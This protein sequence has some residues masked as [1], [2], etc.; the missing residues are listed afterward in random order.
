MN[1]ATVLPG[2]NRTA[3]WFAD[4][5]PGT[6]FDSIEKVLLHTTE[7]SGWPGYQGGAVAPNLTGYPDQAARAMLWRAHFPVN[8]SSRALMHT[9]TQPTNGDHVVQIELVGTC[10]PG[11][12]GLY[13]PGAPEWALAGVADMLA[14]LHAEW[15]VPLVST[16]AWRAYNAPGDGQRLSDN[17]YD[18]YRGILGHQHAPQ[19]DHR[20]PGALNVARVLQ[21]AT[22]TG[23]TVS[24]ENPTL[25]EIQG[26]ILYYKL[27]ANHVNPLTMLTRTYD[28]VNILLAKEQG[29]DAVLSAITAALPGLA[30]DVAARVV[31]ALPATGSGTGGAITPADVK[32]AVREVLTEGTGGTP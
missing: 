6:V 5:H 2:A 11:G 19:N 27:D 1:R 24:Q 10:V 23:G 20:D 3:Q 17:A 18:A 4:D 22:T 15:G 28:A 31:A 8:M 7:G 30:E 13:W 25:Q 26:G 9:R 16:V 21:L 14:W 29:Q 12:P 32:A